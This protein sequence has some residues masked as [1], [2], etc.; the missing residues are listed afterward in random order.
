MGDV[1]SFAE[2]QAAR[3]RTRA[4]G[5]EWKNLERSLQLMRI[6]LAAI[7]T[8]LAAAPAADQADLLSRVEKLAAMIGYGM[9]M[10]GDLAEGVADDPTIVHRRK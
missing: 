5:P 1:I 2:I 3:R 10:L 7:A 9:R 6:N 4:R 8:E